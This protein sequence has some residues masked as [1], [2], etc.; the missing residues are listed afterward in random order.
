MPL[1]SR[2]AA[3]AQ[4]SGGELDS[5]TQLQEQGPR[6]STPPEPCQPTS[7]RAASIPMGPGRCWILPQWLALKQ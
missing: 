4:L 6:G 2:A 1:F 5:L 3:A 7:Q